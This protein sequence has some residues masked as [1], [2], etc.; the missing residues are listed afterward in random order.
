VAV[1][2]REGVDDLVGHL[3]GADEQEAQI[4]ISCERPQSAVNHD[5]GSSVPAEEVDGDPHGDRFLGFTGNRL[6]G[7]R[8]CPTGG[9]VRH[10]EVRPR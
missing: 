6:A 10:A 1:G 5:G 2:C 9:R 3:A 8:R 7:L 4:G